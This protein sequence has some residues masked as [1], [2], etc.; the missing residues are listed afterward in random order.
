MKRPFKFRYKDADGKPF[1][2]E[3]QLPNDAVQFVA[4]DKNG[5]EVERRPAMKLLKKLLASVSSVAVMRGTTIA[6]SV[7]GLMV[8]A[9]TNPNPFLAWLIGALNGV[10]VTLIWA[11]DD[12]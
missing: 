9:Q 7:F 6:S 2:K 5:K 8:I 10:Y 12:E 4:Y 3:F 11:C 1:Y